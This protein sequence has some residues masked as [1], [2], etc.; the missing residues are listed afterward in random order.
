M[1]RLRRSIL[2]PLAAPARQFAG[3]IAPPRPRLAST[4][5]SNKPHYDSP[6][7]DSAVLY[8]GGL[9]AR[10]RGMF[11]LAAGF[12]MGGGGL[13]GAGL[14]WW[15]ATAASPPEEEDKQQRRRRKKEAVLAAREEAEGA[16]CSGLVRRWVWWPWWPHW[17]WAEAEVRRGLLL[18]RAASAGR[19]ALSSSGGGAFA[20]GARCTAVPLAGAEA[21][22]KRPSGG[23]GDDHWLTRCYGIELKTAA[24]AKRLLHLAER[25]RLPDLLDLTDLVDLHRDLPRREGAA[26]AAHRGG[27]RQVGCRA[28]LRAREVDRPSAA[29]SAG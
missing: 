21:T 25:A 19:E 20:S 9:L 29:P 26:A 4:S 22:T 23:D 6:L 16:V 28:P 24:G 27:A 12:F 10:R 2:P 11:S 5:A 13:S 18:L 14:L 3:R 17:Q 7:L 1:H 8:L 15:S